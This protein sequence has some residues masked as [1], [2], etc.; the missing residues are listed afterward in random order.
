MSDVATAMLYYYDYIPPSTANNKQQTTAKPETL[1]YLA[2][3][4]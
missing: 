1:D 4:D 3:I 2:L